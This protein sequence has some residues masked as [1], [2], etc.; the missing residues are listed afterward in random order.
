MGPALDLLVRL[1][2]IVLGM[3]TAVRLGPRLHVS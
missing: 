2:V 3:L 1:A